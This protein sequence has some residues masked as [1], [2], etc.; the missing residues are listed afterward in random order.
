MSFFRNTLWAL[1]AVGF[2][3]STLEA[4]PTSASGTT[5][6]A[7]PDPTKD[8]RIQRIFS[9]LHP[10]YPHLTASEVVRTSNQ[11]LRRMYEHLYHVE[12]L[13]LL[14]A[15]QKAATVPLKAN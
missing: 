14:E 6:K 8:P 10:C 3:A 9:D 7:A 2:L 4:K 11:D 13:G 5:P 12:G 15:K 1:L